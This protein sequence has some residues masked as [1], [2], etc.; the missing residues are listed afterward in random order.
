[1]SLTIDD[2]FGPRPKEEKKEEKKEAPEEVKKQSQPP[3]PSEQPEPPSKGDEPIR[4]EAAETPVS[5]VPSSPDKDVAPVTDISDIFGTTVSTPEQEETP[6]EESVTDEVP[7]SVAAPAE[8]PKE[9]LDSSVPES[10]VPEIPVTEEPQQEAP[11]P[12]PTQAAPVTSG[13]ASIDDIFGPSASPTTGIPQVEV[14]VEPILQVETDV[15]TTPTDI[16]TQELGRTELPPPPLPS[17]PDKF[18]TSPEPPGESRTFLIYG[19]KGDSKTTTALSFPGKI[20]ALSFDHKTVEIWAEFFDNDPRIT[21]YDAIRYMDYSSPDA[22]LMSSEITLVYINII[23]DELRALPEDDYPD[24][25]VIDGLEEYTKVCEMVMRYRNGIRMTQGVEWSYWKE[26]RLYLKQIHLKCMSVSKRGIIYTTFPGRRETIKDNKIVESVKQPKW[27][28]V[29]KDQTDIVIAV[30][31][32]QTPEGKRFFATVESSK[33]RLIPT[34]LVA[35][36]TVPLGERP[37]VYDI[38]IK[39]GKGGE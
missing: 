5:Q 34:G 4:E 2:L 28:D 25:I 23:L 30:E 39:E 33:Y 36:I 14:A 37:N 35:D 20:A 38:L 18:D 1:M 8:I 31:S 32:R 11:T 15:L 16:L 17:M 24:W 21:V 13:P 3:A 12:E 9:T 10:T 19:E 29:M 6:E 7:P 26:R 27:V 22:W